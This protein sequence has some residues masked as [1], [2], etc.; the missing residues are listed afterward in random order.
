MRVFAISLAVFLSLHLAFCP[1]ALAGNLNVRSTGSKVSTVS[2]D[3]PVRRVGKIKLPDGVAVLSEN[4]IDI[5]FD[6]VDLTQ[7]TGTSE[8]KRSLSGTCFG[9][10]TGVSKGRPCVTGYAYIDGG[11]S[12]SEIDQPGVTDSISLTDG[13]ACHGQI[14]S[15]T[16]D[17]VTVTT[18]GGEKQ[19]D[20]TKIKDV[21]SP[22]VFTVSFPYAEDGRSF[23][24]KFTSTDDTKV[25]VSSPDDVKKQSLTQN[26]SNRKKKIV[27]AIVV[28]C[29][30]ATAIAVPIAVSA[31]GRH[32]NNSN[33]EL[34]QIA[35]RNLFA[36]REAA[37]AQ[38]P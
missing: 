9:M 3:A 36:S 35:L 16:S 38:L 18:S 12:F 8:K 7:K 26:H 29:L 27:F 28:A 6:S 19:I 22:R 23:E 11:T 2:G 32:H 20:I 15:V 31:G 21:S 13:T 14:T 17:H 33:N 4:R 5:L 30:V 24:A 1:L 37:G 10:T 34:N 25:G